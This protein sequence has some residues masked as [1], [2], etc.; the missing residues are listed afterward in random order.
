MIWGAAAAALL[1]GLALGLVVRQWVLLLIPL[2][3]FAGMLVLALV[4]SG[5]GGETDWS[6]V[7]PVAFLSG[8]APMALGIAIGVRL[9][10]PPDEPGRRP[11]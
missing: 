1:L 10:A 5:P 2:V 9:V 8:T 4:G 3:P 7:I 6:R 11:S